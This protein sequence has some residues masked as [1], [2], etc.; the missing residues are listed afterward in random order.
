MTQKIWN[1]KFMCNETIQMSGTRRLNGTL[2]NT[3]VVNNGDGT[4]NIAITNHGLTAGCYVQILSTTNYN[5]V[6]KVISAPDAN[7]I[8]VQAT[9]IAETPAGTE[10]Y[11]VAFQPYADFE[12]LETR[13]KLSGASA[14]ENYIHL[15]DANAGAA[16]DATLDTTAMNGLTEKVI[17]WRD[18]T[19]RRFFEIGD[20][21]AA[22]YV[23]TN[24]LTWGLTMIFRMRA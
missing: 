6:K 13:L 11:K 3:A 4:V 20:V 2:D 14:A 18:A 21:I 19:K 24:N 22:T 8:K 23:N 15:L 16:F 10:T 12:L 1:E 7:T 17:V 5:G 9:Y